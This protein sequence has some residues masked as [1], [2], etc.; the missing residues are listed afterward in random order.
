MT[1]ATKKVKKHGLWYELTHTHSLTEQEYKRMV[2]KIIAIV[3]LFFLISFI[4]FFAVAW[5]GG[6]NTVLYVFSTIDYTVYAL[7]FIC[8]L[9]GY[10]ISF[11]KW[12]YFMQILGLKVP[13]GKNLAV[14]LSLYSMELTPGR[15]G[16][17]L[18]A[19]TL[20]R[21]TNIRFINIV[22]IVTMDIFTD[23]LGIA[24]LALIAAAFFSQYFWYVVVVD[25]I[26]LLPFVFL[27]NPWFFKILKKLGGK[28]GRIKSFT[29]Y[30]EEYFT[31]QSKLNKPRVY[32][33]AI[34]FTLPSAFFY[35]LSLYFSLFAIGA[36][37]HLGGSVSIYSI[38]Q[39][40]G[41]VTSLPGNI[42]VT[43]G[44]LV[45]LLEDIFHLSGGVSS[46][47]TIMTRIASLW[48]GVILG[49]A[50][51]AYT[52]RFWKPNAKKK[53]R[54]RKGLRIKLR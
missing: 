22:P 28:N 49:G 3:G 50:F 41:M 4:V 1:L 32:L 21:I 17:V 46:A 7:A 10:L 44:F 37:V 42:G 48:F 35:A 13:F 19:Y 6:I 51:L 24:M 11:A 18:T 34:M 26:L 30:G 2:R 36:V 9:V 53:G 54:K 38:S 40:A 20:N 31:S 12:N 52:I 16:R 27:L 45:G 8:V 25:G 39:V 33:L 29:L 23:F 5:Y 47:V 14:Y 43:D 15:I